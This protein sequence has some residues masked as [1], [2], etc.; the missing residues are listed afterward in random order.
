MYEKRF[1]LVACAIFSDYRTTKHD[2]R[3]C[4]GPDRQANVYSHGNM[5]FMPGTFW[6]DF[7][8][9]PSHCVVAGCDGGLR[10]F[11]IGEL[12]RLKKSSRFRGCGYEAGALSCHS[13]RKFHS[14]RATERAQIHTT[15]NKALFMEEKKASISS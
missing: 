13:L 4:K 15:E 3:P 11:A 8:R 9:S 12:W 7:P 6:R 10:M 2:R 5:S 14:S 1:K